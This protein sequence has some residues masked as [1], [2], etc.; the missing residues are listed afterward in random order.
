MLRNLARCR[1]RQRAHGRAAHARGARHPGIRGGSRPNSSYKAVLRVGH[2]CEGKPTTAIR[3]QI[4][5]GV[6]AVKPMP[7]PG[8]QLATVKDK[9]ERPYDYFGSELTEGVQEIAWSGGELR[10]DF[11]DEFVFVG[12]LTDF[13][14]GTVLQLSDRAGMCR[15]G[16]PLDRDPG[17]RPGSGRA[18]GA[19]AAADDRQGRKRAADAAAGGREAALRPSGRGDDRCGGAVWHRVSR[20]F[21]R[22][23]AWRGRARHAVLLESSPAADAVLAEAPEQIVLRFNEPVRPTVVR[24]LRA[25]D[26]AS[27]EL[28]ARRGH[29]H[30]A[31]RAAAER[32]AGR[33][34]MC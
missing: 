29:R 22:R 12:R 24:L 17:G 4:P 32:L 19:G 16:A 34:P 33:Q 23:C 25:A 14:P 27:V 7:K 26:G 18:R 20:C 15:R 6:I 10:D 30:R 13:E 11:Y 8:W 2:G 9:Y 3:V 5:E 1:A 31:P 21:L 28:E